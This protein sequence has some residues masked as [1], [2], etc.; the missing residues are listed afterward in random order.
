VINT[1]SDCWFLKRDSGLHGLSS[2]IYQVV[3]GKCQTKRHCVRVGVC[4][5]FGM[6]LGGGETECGR[7]GWIKLDED[8]V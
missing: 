6:K 1:F 8:T 4:V 3:V 2:N 7:A 5:E